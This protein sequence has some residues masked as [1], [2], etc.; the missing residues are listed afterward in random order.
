MDTLGVI[1]IA[2]VTVAI[3]VFVGALAATAVGAL[4]GWLVGLVFSGSMAHLQD[5]LHTTAEPYQI[6]A[7]LGFIGSF[8]RSSVTTNSK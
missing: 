4:V 6:G 5:F 1:L 8:F 3:A 2:A 7:M